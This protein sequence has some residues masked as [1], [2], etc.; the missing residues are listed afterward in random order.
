MKKVEQSCNFSVTHPSSIRRGKKISTVNL[1]NYQYIEQLIERYFNCQTTVQ[2]EE[3]LRSFFSQE[4][5]PGHLLA[6]QQL[7]GYLGKEHEI[8]VSDDFDERMMQLISQPKIHRMSFAPLFRAAAIVAMVLT[9][10][11][12][13]Q[14][15][16]REGTAIT[17]SN[18]QEIVSPYATQDEVA[19]ILRP[20]NVNQASVTREDSLRNVIR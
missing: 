18:G 20:R 11:N 4:D 7:F 1:M 3:I 13:T 2:E 6:Y 10:G 17:D 16:L 5:V 14:Q 19:D 12:A 9:V 8:H 15:A